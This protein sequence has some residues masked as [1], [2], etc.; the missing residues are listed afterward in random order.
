M[1]KTEAE[2]AESSGT[3]REILLAFVLGLATLGVSFCT[4]QSGL[5]SGESLNYYVASQTTFGASLSSVVTA[6]QFATTESFGLMLADS[7][8]K[9]AEEGINPVENRRVADKLEKRYVDERI[10]KAARKVATMD[11]LEVP[12][13]EE[14]ITQDSDDLT[15]DGAKQLE[16]ARYLSDKG[17]RFEMASLYF[18]LVMFFGG[19]GAVFRKAKVQNAMIVLSVVLLVV[20]TVRMATL[21]SEKM[22]SFD[23]IKIDL[24]SE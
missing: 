13:Y 1:A 9:M 2:Q 16:K 10:V 24:M 18:T 19:M 7:H 3:W 17:D 15:T 22:P 21:M 11:E 8:R 20:S 14:E 4:F 23:H 6:V 12:E 5:A